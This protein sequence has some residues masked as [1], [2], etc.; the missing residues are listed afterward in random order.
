MT[1]S[2]TFFYDYVS[3]ASYLAWT[4][5]PAICVRHGAVLERRPI[6]LGGLFKSVGNASPI[7]VPAKFAWMIADQ[8]RYARRYGVPFVKSDRFPYDTVAAMR[9][10]LWAKQ[11]G[12]LDAWDEAFFKAGWGQGRDIGDLET[13]KSIAAAAGFDPEAFAGAIQT[14]EIKKALID[15][16][17]EA[18]AAGAF[19]APTFVVDGVLHWGQDRLEWIEAALAKR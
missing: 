14:D 13:V 5:L 8:A 3:S 11:L 16:T 6:L 18:A 7:S 2:V 9:G 17:A 12:R 1:K 19:G 15:A 10:A 4:Q